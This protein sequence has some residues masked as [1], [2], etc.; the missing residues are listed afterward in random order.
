MNRK[1]KLK[2]HILNCGNSFTGPVSICA[3]VNAPTKTAALRLLQSALPRQVKVPVPAAD[4]DRIAYINV[5]FGSANLRPHH[6]T[7]RDETPDDAAE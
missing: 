5:Y 2:P 6:F 1:I 3:R 4:A 7:T